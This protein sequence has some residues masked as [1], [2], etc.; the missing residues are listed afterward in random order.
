MVSRQC[1]AAF[2]GVSPTRE[3]DML[4]GPTP[5]RAATLDAQIG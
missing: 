2:P 5:R 1:H 4:A 3:D